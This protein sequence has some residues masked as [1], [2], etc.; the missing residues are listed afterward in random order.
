M[1]DKRAF[2]SIRESEMK[3]KLVSA[4][5]LMEDLR[6]VVTDAEELLRATAGQ[7]RPGSIRSDQERASLVRKPI[8]CRVYLCRRLC[9]IPHS[10]KPSGP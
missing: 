2:E 5:K 4:D 1:V 3:S 9:S 7:A 10:A 6:L 8:S